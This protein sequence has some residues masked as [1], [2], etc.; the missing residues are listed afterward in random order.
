MSPASAPRVVDRP[1]FP[2][3]SRASPVPSVRVPASLCAKHNPSYN[4]RARESPR[5]AICSVH[6][7]SPSLLVAPASCDAQFR[8][9]CCTMRPVHLHRQHVTKGRLAWPSFLSAYAWR[10]T[11]RTSRSRHSC[12]SLR[13][14]ARCTRPCRYLHRL[15]D[16]SRLP[17]HLFS[18]ATRRGLG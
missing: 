17:H 15:R 18:R 11:R 14:P 3:W 8:Q 2:G 10:R 1:R 12:S 4:S 9:Q 5:A 16:S 6:Q 13:S 7:T